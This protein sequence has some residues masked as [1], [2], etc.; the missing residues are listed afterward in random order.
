MVPVNQPHSTTLPS[1]ATATLTP[2]TW[3]KLVLFTN[4]GESLNAT[5]DHTSDDIT[6]LKSGIYEVKFNVA[7]HAGAAADINFAPH[8]DGALLQMRST[9]TVG[10]TSE[11]HTVAGSGIVDFDAD[12]Q[13]L[14]LRVKSDTSTTVTVTDMNLSLIRRN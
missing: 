7:F 1:A 4:N 13:V 6:A 10:A 3:T 11:L 5:V 2:A 14:D 8:K 12:N 9:T